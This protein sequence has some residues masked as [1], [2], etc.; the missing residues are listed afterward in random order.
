MQSPSN[1]HHHEQAPSMVPL[2]LLPLLSPSRLL[3]GMPLIVLLCLN[4]IAQSFPAPVHHF[5]APLVPILFWA[6]AAGLGRR[7]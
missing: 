5:H 4:E 3:V 2:A 1:H 7:F 6:A